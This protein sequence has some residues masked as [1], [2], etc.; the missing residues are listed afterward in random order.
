M[1]VERRL[2]LRELV[3]SDADDG[4]VI[5]DAPGR[6]R[7]RKRRGRRRRRRVDVAGGNVMQRVMKGIRRGVMIVI[8]DALRRPSFFPSTAAAA[9]L[10]SLLQSSTFV[11]MAEK[12]ADLRRK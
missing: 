4:V 1:E 10:V 6:L 2:S 8:R 11:R 3:I 5:D 12:T 9:S 7:W